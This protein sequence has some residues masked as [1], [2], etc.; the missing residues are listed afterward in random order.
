MTANT[1]S[2]R[3][4]RLF[5]GPIL[6]VED[7]VII[8]MDAEELIRDFGAP[9]VITARTVT[10]AHEKIDQH[11][12]FAAI[13]DF[14]LEDETSSTIADRLSELGVPFVFATGFSST[15][16]LPD[17]FASHTLLDKPFTASDLA[18]AFDNL[19]GIEGPEALT[20]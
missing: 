18:Q 11:S 13:L 16:D 17:R 12:F 9:D 5:E 8:A 3:H 4:A 7:N 20:A 14:N 1:V 19:A 6:L 15:D 2:N 10:E